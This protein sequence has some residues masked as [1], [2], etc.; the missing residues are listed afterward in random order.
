M[1]NPSVSGPTHPPRAQP[2]PAIPTWWAR[3]TTN[4]SGWALIALP[5]F[6][7]FGMFAFVLF[8]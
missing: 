8:I 1:S 5:V 4:D 7:C 2:R 3:A 6:I